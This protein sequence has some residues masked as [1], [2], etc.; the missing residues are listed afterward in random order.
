M[1]YLDYQSVFVWGGGEYTVSP[2][3]NTVLDSNKEVL[4]VCYSGQMLL[5]DVFPAWHHALRGVADRRHLPRHPARRILN[6]HYL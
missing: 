6:E 5:L 3:I 4:Q 1:Y 2:R